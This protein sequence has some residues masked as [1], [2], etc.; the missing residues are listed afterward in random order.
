[1]PDKKE[2]RTRTWAYVVYPH[3]D[4]KNGAPEN[5]RELLDDLHVAWAESPL[6]DKD[7]NPDGEKKKAH[8]HI[9]V[10]WDA[11]QRYS[12]AE[13]I[14]KLLNAPIPQPVASLKGMIRYFIHRDNPEKY[15]YDEAEI[16][17]HGDIDVHGLLALSGSA[18]NGELKKIMKYIKDNHIHH[19]IDLQM[20]AIENNDDWFDI[21]NNRN[22]MAIGATIKSVW[23]KDQSE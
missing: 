17:A 10:V 4:T 18:Q 19:L 22:T 13:K 15:Q 8:W 9:V 14:A 1:M 12:A 21:I 5:W 7:V 3:I 2:T 11:P 23:Q 16:T 6:H 20:Y